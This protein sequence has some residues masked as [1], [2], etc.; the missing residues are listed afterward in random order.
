MRCLQLYLPCDAAAS[1]HDGSTSEDLF[2]FFCL[3]TAPFFRARGADLRGEELYHPQ[4]LMWVPMGSCI[5]KYLT[6][7][8]KRGY[9]FFLKSV[10]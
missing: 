5:C 8:L 3:P 2:N 9:L 7:I 10:P 6:Y 4:F 1:S